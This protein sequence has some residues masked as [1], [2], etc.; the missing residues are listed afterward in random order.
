ME[1]QLDLHRA[2]RDSQHALLWLDSEVGC[3]VG[4]VGI[5]GFQ[6]ETGEKGKEQRPLQLKV[7]VPPVQRGLCVGP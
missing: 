7:Q 4:Y 2:L 6:L 3:Q 5:C 1:E